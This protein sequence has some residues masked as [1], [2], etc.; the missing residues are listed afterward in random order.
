MLRASKCGQQ[1]KV[2]GVCNEH[3]HEISEITTRTLPQ[4]RKLADDT[5]AEVLEM[6]NLHIDRKKIIEYVKVTTKKHLTIKDLFNMKAR[7]RDKFAEASKTTQKR[8]EEI[9]RRIEDICGTKTDVQPFISL[10]GSPLIDLEPETYYEVIADDTIVPI[11]PYSRYLSQTHEQN[12]NYDNIIQS[13]S[14]VGSEE[15]EMNEL[16]AIDDVS[17]DSMHNNK[18]QHK[19]EVERIMPSGF[20]VVDSC[21][22]IE[23]YDIV[24]SSGTIKVENTPIEQSTIEHKL[25]TPKR[26]TLRNRRT[27]SQRH[28]HKRSAGKF[29]SCGHCCLNARLIQKRID[30]L[31]AMEGKLIEE[32]NVLRL[33]KERLIS[34]AAGTL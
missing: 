4:N 2:I 24:Q 29:R 15:I 13:P 14:Q 6:L 9:L 25:P 12:G 23:P 30:V 5:K 16:D 28:R 27:E 32:T 10:P 3:N 17:N 1:L 33:T 34:E 8:K 26:K 22:T 21:E 7:H 31:K 20:T 19:F 18:D 11:S